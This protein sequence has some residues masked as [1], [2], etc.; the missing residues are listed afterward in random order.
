MFRNTQH[1]HFIGI[2]GIGM[3]GMAELLYK[4]GFT[5]SGSDSSISERTTYLSKLGIEISHNHN[6]N[7]IL[8]SDVVVYSSAVDVENIEIESAKLENIP[9]I[10]RAEMLAELLKVKETS[11][12]IAGTHGKT[13]TSSL[14]GSILTEAKLDPTLVICCIVNN[15]N[16]SIII[17][18]FFC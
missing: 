11:I 17:M 2:G 12:A 15:F 5:I 7:N 13:T 14:I 3:S 8:N 4:L 9:V 18:S 6:A 16:I 1:I 10:R